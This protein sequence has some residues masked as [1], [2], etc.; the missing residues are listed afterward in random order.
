M[1]D[2]HNYS[3]ETCDD[4]DMRHMQCNL[5]AEKLLFNIVTRCLGR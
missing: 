5:R 1:K 3:P 4:A 2:P